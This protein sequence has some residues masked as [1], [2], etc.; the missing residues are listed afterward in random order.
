ML[1]S[2]YSIIAILYKYDMVKSYRPL[3]GQMVT[4]MTTRQASALTS[5]TKTGFFSVMFSCSAVPPDV[6]KT[7]KDAWRVPDFIDRIPKRNPKQ[8][9]ESSATRSRL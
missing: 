9:E 3:M 4:Y 7:I 2:F 6:R 8:I 5:R 1:N